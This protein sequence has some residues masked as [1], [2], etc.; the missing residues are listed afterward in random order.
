MKQPMNP[1]SLFQFNISTQIVSGVHAADRLAEAVESLSMKRILIVTDFGVINAGL[2]DEVVERLQG[3]GVAR[4]PILS[5]TGTQGG[6][7]AKA[8]NNNPSG[9][10][11][12]PLLM[13]RACDK[14]ITRNPRPC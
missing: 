1:L 3:T 8:C 11:I 14:Q 9:H 12:A 7:H 6:D 2:L 4:L 5:H 10:L 13:I